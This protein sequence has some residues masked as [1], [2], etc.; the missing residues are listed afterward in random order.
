MSDSQAIAD[1]VDIEAL[2][3]ESIDSQMVDDYD[4]FAS[5]F[6]P[7]GMWRVPAVN[8]EFAGREEI[9]AGI[10]RLK[11]EVW[12]LSGANHASRHDPAGRRH[13]DGPGIRPE[14]RPLSRRRLA[15]ELLRLPRPLPAGS[16]RL[17]VRRARRRDPVPRHLSAGGLAP[18]RGGG[19]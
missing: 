5:L 13:C 4:R 2:L 12:G 15:P 3:G 7:D 11:T 17:E 19:G 1:R 6:T 9:R 14:F 8:A 10:K 18:H 16:R